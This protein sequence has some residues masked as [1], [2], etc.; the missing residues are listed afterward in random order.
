MPLQTVV[1]IAEDDDA[2]RSVLVRSLTREGFGVVETW[3][4]TEALRALE[5]NSDL[6]DVLLS[7]VAMP[8]MSGPDLAGR[9]S[10]RWPSIRIGFITAYAGEHAVRMVTTGHP[11]L[12]KPFTHDELVSF[13][14]KLA[15]APAGQLA[16]D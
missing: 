6:P 1:L 9:V 14:R 5:S 13:V 15:A 7:D 8:G 16:G 10:V 11:V 3:D 2:V 12:P 4:G